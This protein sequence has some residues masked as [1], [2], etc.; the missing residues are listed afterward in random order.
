[1]YRFIKIEKL[2]EANFYVLTKRR[3]TKRDIE[4]MWSNLRFYFDFLPTSII[5][6]YNEPYLF[7]TVLQ[8]NLRLVF[9][10]NHLNTCLETPDH[11]V[12]KEY[13]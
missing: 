6:Y 10:I 13:F 7:M 9:E 3:T 12:W 2:E 4:N 11:I 5:R 8:K 1:M